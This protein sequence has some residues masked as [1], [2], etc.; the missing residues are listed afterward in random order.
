MTLGITLF[1]QILK[2]FPLRQSYTRHSSTFQPLDKH[3]SETPFLATSLLPDRIKYTEK[4]TLGRGMLRSFLEQSE[5]LFPFERGLIFSLF[6][7]PQIDD[8]QTCTQ[9]I[10]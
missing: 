10:I 8:D 6:V 2:Q 1:P 9:K 3:N 5:I 4:D 7:E